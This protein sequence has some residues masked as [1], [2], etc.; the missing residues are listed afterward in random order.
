MRKDTWGWRGGKLACTVIDR[1][2]QTDILKAE[3]CRIKSMPVAAMQQYR[4]RGLPSGVAATRPI[5]APQLEQPRT[6]QTMLAAGC[7]RSAEYLHRLKRCP[8]RLRAPAKGDPVV[9]MCRVGS[10]MITAALVTIGLDGGA[11]AALFFVC[12]Q[13]SSLALCVFDIFAKIVFSIYR[14]QRLSSSAVIIY[15]LLFAVKFNR[16]KKR[17]VGSCVDNNG[18]LSLISP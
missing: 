9:R 11:K 5:R 7:G 2:F 18:N 3:V 1:V 16:R 15:H 6:Y 13:D 17:P 12:I 8:V 10:V 4:P 14:Q